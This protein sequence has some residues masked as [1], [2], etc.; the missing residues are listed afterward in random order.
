M[1]PIVLKKNS[2]ISK[3]KFTLFLEENKIET[4][5]ML[6]LTN[7]PVYKEIFGELEDK[8]PVTKWINNNGFYIGCHQKLDKENLD[9]IVSKFEDFFKLQE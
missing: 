6:P 1:F 2:G 7:Q 5:D 8:Y 9:Y 3:Q 4:R